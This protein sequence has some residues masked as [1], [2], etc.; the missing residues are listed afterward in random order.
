[1][2]P[3]FDP[4]DLAR[5]LPPAG[6]T[7]V[8]GCSAESLLLADAVAAAGDALGDMTFTGI[9]VPGLNRR[10]YAASPATRIET[11]FLTPELKALG[12]QV[13]FLPH[14]YQDIGRRLAAVPID[15]AL[16]MVS[17]PDERGMC[18]FGP[19]VDFLADLWP[20]IPVRIAHI[21]PLLPR[22][23]GHAGIPFEAL[24]AIV[25]APQEPLGIA[26]RDDDK[27]ASIAA[28]VA[29]LVADG[30]TIQT[31]LGSVPDAVLRALTGRRGLRVHSGLIGDGILDLLEADAL[32]PGQ[33]V[34]A[35]V[36]IGSPRLYAAIGGPCFA[37]QPVSVTHDL[38]T[39][40][41]IPRFVAI[42]S[43][44]EVDLFGQAYAECGPAG[45]MSGPGGASDF[46]RAA[47]AGGGLRIV[48]MAATGKGGISRIVAPGA[49]RGPVSLGV[50]D[51]DIV[52]TE[53]GAADLRGRTHQG[54]ARALIAVAAPDHR[55]ILVE[56]WRRTEATLS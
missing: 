33:S 5:I 46:A 45:F 30:S 2:P 56:A 15:A 53:H 50:M 1:M 24:T 21:N 23:Q 55:D 4:A 52:V 12:G 51:T 13:D 34:T 43:A 19:A 10:T 31:G 17:P 6:R 9:F 7:L 37:F 11:F 49:G 3:Q 44:I 29:P 20:R 8:G 41:A 18:S 35:G 40:A 32:A 47:R 28:H 26:A 38:R 22:T 54:R 42:N 14:C 48:T 27:A 39:V 16:F 25:E 36:A